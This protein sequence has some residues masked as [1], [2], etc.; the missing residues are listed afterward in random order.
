MSTLDIFLITVL[1]IVMMA[2][3][4]IL[5]GKTVGYIV[6]KCIAVGMQL[7]SYSSAEAS[8][9]GIHGED[10]EVY[11]VTL[12]Q[13]LMFKQLAADNPDGF[14][15]TLDGQIIYPDEGYAVADMRHE[16]PTSDDALMHCIAFASS[17][18]GSG[19]IGGWLNPD[20]G[21]FVWDSVSI[22]Y[23][24]ERAIKAGK[25]NMQHSIFD[26][27]QKQDIKL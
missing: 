2:G 9:A 13:M 1:G 27:G 5:I 21:E 23:S 22:M 14:T 4:V 17:A 10:L 12:E 16:Y 6:D 11:G 24:R 7:H 8:L 25:A 20:S 15:A 19:L 26:Y 3:L 18:Y